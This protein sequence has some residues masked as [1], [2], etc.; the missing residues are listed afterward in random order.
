M[1]FA[2]QMGTPLDSDH[3]SAFDPSDTWRPQEFVVRSWVNAA[4]A[5]VRF[6]AMQSTLLVDD[7]VIEPV[8]RAEVGQWA[9]RLYATLPPI[10]VKAVPRPGKR[11]DRSLQKLRDGQALRIVMLGDSIIN[12]TGNSPFDVLLERKYPGAKVEVITSVR[13]GGGCQYYKLENRVEQYVLQY[14]PDLLVIGGISNDGPASIPEVIHQVRAK[15]D[16]DILVMSGAVCLQLKPETL[17]PDLPEPQRQARLRQMLSYR[18]ELAK[19]CREEHVE[20]L[21]LRQLWDDYATAIRKH[22][23][24]L[25]RDPVHANERG[26]AV[27]SRILEA[28]FSPASPTPRAV[29]TNWGNGPAK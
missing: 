14:R 16:P 17:F 8:S 10:N 4:T 15:Q 18:A 28:Y 29:T 12:D 6:H 21:D 27:L 11:L 23:L 5:E 26:R 7:V 22:P 2:D 1:A 13:G 24:W 25:M 3:Y 19:L 20:Y 9:D